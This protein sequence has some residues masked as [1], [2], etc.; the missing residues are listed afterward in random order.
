MRLALCPGS[1][2]PPTLGHLDIVVRAAALF[3]EVVVAVAT[4][5]AKSPLLPAQRRADLLHEVLA[6]TDVGERVRVVL[7]DGGLLARQAADLGA[8]AVVKGVRTA[9]DVEHETPMALMNRRLTGVETVLL[10]ADPAWA[11]V[12]SSLVK[13]VA[14][15]GGDVG[16]LVPPPVAR[17]LAEALCSQAGPASR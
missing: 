17:A 9:S 3:D 2:D 7:L 5:H 16:A 1:F 14:S 4:N 15:L 10:N 13:E 11:H 8:V 6:A 12:S